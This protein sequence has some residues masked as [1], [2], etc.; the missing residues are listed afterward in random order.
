MFEAIRKHSKFVMILLFLLIIPSFIFVGIDQNYFSESSPTV[1]RVDGHEIKQSDWDNAHRMESDQLRAANPE[2]DA[3]LLDSPQARYATLERMVRDRVLVAAAQKMHMVAS[4]AQLVRSLQQIPAI[5]ALKRAD[6]TLDAEAYRALVGAQG[7]TPEGFE[8]NLR[9]N[10]SLSQVMGSAINSSFVTDSQVKLAM[11]ALYQRREVQVAQFKASDF[12]SKVKATPEELQAY[13]KAHPDKFQQAEQASVEY[14]VLDS[15]SVQASMV[16]NEDDLRTYYQENLS[17]LAGQEER[18]AS[19]ILINATKDASAADRTKAREQAQA[20]LEQV[21]KDP[22]SFAAVAKQSSQDSGTAQS[23]GDL[24]FFTRGD[25]VKP[26]SDAA[27]ALKKGDISDVVESD[28]GFHII[29]LTDIKTPPQPSFA[30]LRPRLEKDLKEQQAQRKYAEV[31]EQFANGVYEQSDNLQG[32]AEKLKLT[33]QK[34][35]RVSRIP[36]PGAQGALANPRFLEALFAPE[37][38]E[39]KRNTE[40]VEIGSG[41]MAA[42]RVTA[43]SPAHTLA[44]EEVADKVQALYV[45]QKS[46]ELARE[47]GQAKLKAWKEQPAGAALGAAVVI[48]R[49]QPQNLPREVIDAALHASVEGLPAWTGVDLGNLGYAVIKVNSVVERPA[50]DAQIVAAQKQQL[51]QWWAGAE[52]AAYYEM[53]KARFKV[54]I[55]VDRP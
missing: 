12:A 28:F 6:G 13:Y 27:Y 32:V 39:S 14:V 8:A 34:A 9:S 19:H 36:A 26:F 35:E 54:Q 24:G 45:A 29:Q 17:R 44:F 48:G 1:A 55:K 41:M 11:D 47:E 3:K 38:L 4:D 30:E 50:Q 33:V 49:D 5:A 7:M 46:A 2:V 51:A 37:S 42:G 52:G 16:L 18:R 43:Y 22:E 25:M 31:A 21:R 10:L 23:G 15:A 53:L 20:L 40:A